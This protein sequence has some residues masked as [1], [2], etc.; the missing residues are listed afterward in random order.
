MERDRTEV[1]FG[2]NGRRGGGGNCE[3]K[4]MEIFDS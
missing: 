3:V 2:G 1:R 4:Y